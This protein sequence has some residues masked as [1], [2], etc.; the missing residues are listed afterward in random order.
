MRVGQNPAKSMNRVV[1]PERITVAVLSYIPFLSGYY[2]E[3]L[4]VLKLCLDSI[5]ENTSL[6]FDLFVFDNGSCNEVKEYLIE[7]QIRGAIQY[8]LFSRKNLGKGGAWNII[9]DGAPGE[10]IAYCDGDA[11]F[12]T[13]WLEKSMEILEKYPKVGM[14]TARPMRTNTELFTSTLKWAQSEKSV[15]LEK[16]SFIPFDE[17]HDFAS[18]M[19][20]SEEKI[21]E[22]YQSTTDY[23]LTYKGVKAFAGANH[24]QFIGWKKTL[25]SL[26]PLDMQKPIGQVKQL[27]E[28][29]NQKGYLRLMTAQPLVQNMSNRVPVGKKEVLAIQKPKEKKPISIKQFPVLKK[30]LLGIYD[31]IFRMY[32]EE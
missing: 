16:G 7:E 8:L 27:D 13:G 17:F 22:I 11:L 4:D 9:F 14:V 19:G 31:K 24:F 28:K 30:G 2:S 21:D 23:R 1:K 10:V 3:S 5:Y 32:Y 29:L 26:L 25:Q 6:L 12:Y 20:Y 15:Q 18:T